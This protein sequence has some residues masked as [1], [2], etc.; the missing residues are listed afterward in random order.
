MS[1]ESIELDE[2]R[3]KIIDVEKELNAKQHHMENLHSESFKHLIS[4]NM[5]YSEVALEYAMFFLDECTIYENTISVLK[6]SSKRIEKRSKQKIDILE[7]INKD[8]PEEFYSLEKE[9]IV[10]NSKVLL[11]INERA[12]D[13]YK[14]MLIVKKFFITLILGALKNDYSVAEE[15]AKNI[16]S[17]IINFAPLD[18]NIKGFVSV[19][20]LIK[21]LANGVN[22]LDTQ[23][24]YEEK[25]SNLDS[26]LR[27]IDYQNKALDLL[28]DRIPKILE[29]F[30]S[31]SS[32]N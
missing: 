25:T 3:D 8:S 5:I 17:Q 32:T 29:N 11:C 26:E 23:R 21:T 16:L 9:L 12:I 19:V 13:S 7:Y 20:E 24:I 1:I 15:N 22:N 10:T 28:I 30:E 18:P 27:K 14:F 6:N 4:E 2:L 31:I